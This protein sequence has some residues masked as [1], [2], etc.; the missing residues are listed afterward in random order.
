MV[1]SVLATG[2]AT[3]YPTWMAHDVFYTLSSK[4]IEMEADLIALDLMAKS[5]YNPRLAGHMLDVAEPIM[6]KNHPVVSRIPSVFKT[7]PSFKTRQEAIEKNAPRFMDHY[8]KGDFMATDV[9][10]RNLIQFN[11]RTPF[12]VSQLTHE[13]DGVFMTKA[14]YKVKMAAKEKMQ[15]D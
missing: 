8:E 9:D 1:A 5:G 2:G 12:S 14:D 15:M 11:A 13:L 4:R 10:T 7:H 6:K 3:L